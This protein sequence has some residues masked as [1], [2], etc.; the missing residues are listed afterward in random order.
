M[1]KPDHHPMAYQAVVW[2][3]FKDKIALT[4]SEQS[5]WYRRHRCAA[6]TVCWLALLLL[7]FESWWA[8]SRDSIFV[9]CLLHSSKLIL[10]C[11]VGRI[12]CFYA[13]VFE[14]KLWDFWG[15]VSS[16]TAAAANDN[17]AV[18]F[19]LLTLFFLRKTKDVFFSSSW[20]LQS[21]LS[22]VKSSTKSHKHL[23]NRMVKSRKF[24]KTFNYFHLSSLS[25]SSHLT[26]AIISRGKLTAFSKKWDSLFWLTIISW[27]APRDGGS[28]LRRSITV[29]AYLAFTTLTMRSTR[30]IE[31]DNEKFWA[32]NEAQIL[33]TKVV[34][35]ALG[36]VVAM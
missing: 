2:A 33:I 36:G 29:E 23:V 7:W 26:I 21:F 13:A 28:N 8:K 3:R 6:P 35:M 17:M 31:Y 25:R 14:W 4:T 10:S 20:K 18:V 11:S 1:L 30:E 22:L 19:L 16:R 12:Y 15:F 27:W 34:V 32:A 5:F 24:E 9:K